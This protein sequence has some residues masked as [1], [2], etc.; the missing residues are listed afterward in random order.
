MENITNNTQ[1]VVL[2][3]VY[4]KD[5]SK[6]VCLSIESILNQTNLNFRLLTGVRFKM[7]IYC[8]NQYVLI[9]PIIKNLKHCC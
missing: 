7:S 1:V 2:M 3:S 6:H 4:E 9:S 5:N 8:D